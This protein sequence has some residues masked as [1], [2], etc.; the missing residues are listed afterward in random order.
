[1]RPLNLEILAR[2]P[3]RKT[4]SH[5]HAD[6]DGDL[7]AATLRAYRTIIDVVASPHKAAAEG[8]AASLPPSPRC[9]L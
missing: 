5:R 1:V 4:R 9:P 3:D 6:S 8:M 2:S 7:D